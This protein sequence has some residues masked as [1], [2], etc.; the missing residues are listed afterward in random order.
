VGALTASTAPGLSSFTE[1]YPG[2]VGFSAMLGSAPFIRSSGSCLG[3]CHFS[4]RIQ[5]EHQ[6]ELILTGFRVSRQICGSNL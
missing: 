5:V 6:A 4:R 1:L 2:G 3:D